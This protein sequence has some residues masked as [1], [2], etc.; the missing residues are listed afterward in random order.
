MSD[1]RTPS[2]NPFIVS[3]PLWSRAPSRDENGRPFIDFMMI[4]PGLKTANDAVV[5]SHLQKIRNSLQGFENTVAYVD[6]NIKLNLLWVSARQVPGI[7]K[8]IMQAIQRELP[9]AKIVAVDFNPETFADRPR[10]GWL[11]L[12][13][14][15]VKKRLL[16]LTTGSAN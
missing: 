13:G 1:K 14:Q 4:I 16:L 8:L 5:E 2:C 11:V 10:K 3:S 9:Q 12:L 15:K 6:L 7:S